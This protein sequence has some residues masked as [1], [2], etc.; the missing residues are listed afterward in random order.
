M[1][2]RAAALVVAGLLA[3]TGAGCSDDGPDVLVDAVERRTV[4]EVV[5]APAIVTARATA[6]LTAAA[7]GRVIEVLVRDGQPV[8]AGALVVRLD[9]P[10]ARE[11]LRQAQQ[12]DAAAAASTVELPGTDLG[13]VLAQLDAAAAASFAAARAAARSIDDPARRRQAEQGVVAAER[14]YAAAR[15]RA[16]AAAADANAGIGE[17]SDALSA[18]TTAQRTQTR[19]AVALAA[20]TVARLEVR[21]PISGVVTLGGGSGDGA[22]DAGGL[23]DSLPA[24]VR[25]QAESALGGGSGRTDVTPGE[26]A[27][28]VP[29]SAGAPLATVTDVST[30]GLAAEVDETDVFL[31]RPGVGARVELDAVPGATYS[32]RVT[33][34]DVASSSSARGGVAYRVRLALGAGTTADGEPAPVPRP[35][36]SAVANLEV[37]R[38][39]NVLSVPAA[40]VI[41]S[42][43]DDAVWVVRNGKARRQVVRLGAQGEDYSEIRSG[44]G[45]GDRIVVRGADAVRNGDEL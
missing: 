5:D 30:L 11:R 20:D 13:G 21:A 9:S 32:A 40:A 22:D 19:A 6:S 29:V 37:R 18:L 39:A 45:E 31:V 43:S 1:T 44:L 12:A 26:I 41:R 15:A 23:L 17:L 27:V 3:V 2:S 33:A 14:Q 4:V 8:R 10:E 7:D 25:E 16:V 34:V 35:G 38:A 28:G 36:M 24:D 42:G